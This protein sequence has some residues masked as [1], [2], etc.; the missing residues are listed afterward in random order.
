MK[1]FCAIV[2]VAI[3]PGTAPRFE[4]A[5]EA[6][7]ENTRR[8]RGNIAFHFLKSNTSSDAYLFFEV[9]VDETAYVDHHRERHYLRW[10]DH[11][12]PFM[13]RDRTRTFWTAWEPPFETQ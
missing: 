3:L 6:H 11:V 10:R 5:M 2:D 4:A 7:I 1:V 12:A 9:F 8:E 13:E